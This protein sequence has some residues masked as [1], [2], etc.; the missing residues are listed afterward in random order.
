MDLKLDFGKNVGLVFCEFY[1]SI[2]ELIDN[3]ATFKIPSEYLNI[4]YKVKL[5]LKSV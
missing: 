3:Y 4:L 2:F 1:D 5:F